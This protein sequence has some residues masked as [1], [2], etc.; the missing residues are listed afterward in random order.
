LPLALGQDSAA[1]TFD[2]IA[3]M[4]SWEELQKRANIIAL[5]ILPHRT[6]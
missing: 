5:K 3:A 6:P 2:R 4:H 1:I